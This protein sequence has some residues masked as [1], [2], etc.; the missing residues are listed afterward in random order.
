MLIYKSNLT[1]TLLWNHIEG[2]I[3]WSCSPRNDTIDTLKYHFDITKYLQ[4][5]Y[6]RICKIFRLI[7]DMNEFFVHKE[8]TPI[9]C[10]QLS[11]S[12]S[13]SDYE[14]CIFECISST[15]VSSESEYSFV[16]RI[17]KICPTFSHGTGYHR[18]VGEFSKIRYC[19]HCSS[20]TSMTEIQYDIL[21]F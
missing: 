10:G 15:H 6:G 11:E 20:S 17:R 13:N 12:T 16:A 7:I 5:R 1:A 4:A 3:F 14:V 8:F 19:T 9:S 18:S 2:D 21:I